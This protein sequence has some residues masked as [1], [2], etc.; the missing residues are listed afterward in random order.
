M[1]LYRIQGY[2][3]SCFFVYKPSPTS[4]PS[5]LLGC[6]VRWLHFYFFFFLTDSWWASQL[7]LGHVLSLFP[8]I[9]F[10]LAFCLLLFL[11]F[12]VFVPLDHQVLW[13]LRRYRICLQCR[14]S[15]FDPWVGKI[16]QRR[17]WHMCYHI[18]I[19]SSSPFALK[20][21]PKKPIFCFCF[22]ILIPSFVSLRI[23]MIFF[24]LFSF[25]S[26]LLCVVLL[27]IAFPL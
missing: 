4:T 8:W 6:P 15:R 13:Q 9:G 23:L 26:S 14:R 25:K 2:F 18:F 7:V 21:F 10:L 16:P 3:Y 27:P 20:M 22:M 24:F 1:L 12:G 19:S 17:E 11:S 5:K